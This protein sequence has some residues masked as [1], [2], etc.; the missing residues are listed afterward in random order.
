MRQSAQQA[1]M[2]VPGT[3]YEDR[4][5][6]CSTWFERDRANIRLETRRGRIVFN[7]WDEEVRE[8]IEDGYLTAPRAPRPSDADWQPH[9]VAYARSKGLIA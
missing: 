5:Y 7:L 9:A 3:A 2:N 4:D 6:V 1:R 8:A